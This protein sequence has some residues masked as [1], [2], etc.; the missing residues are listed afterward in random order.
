MRTKSKSDILKES[1]IEA[2]PVICH[3]TVAMF[4]HSGAERS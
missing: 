1:E 2:F 4:G 3:P